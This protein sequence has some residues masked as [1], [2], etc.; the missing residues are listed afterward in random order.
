MTTEELEKAALRVLTPSLGWGPTSVSFELGFG[1]PKELDQQH[2]RI[3]D[4]RR[5]VQKLEPNVRRAYEKWLDFYQR[6]NDEAR[7]EMETGAKR[8]LWLR[9]K[10]KE[11]RE[12]ADIDRCV[13]SIPRP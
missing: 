3:A 4:Y 1:N 10:E 9:H 11:A 7:Q 6:E 5:R 8:A 2:A 12:R 13:K